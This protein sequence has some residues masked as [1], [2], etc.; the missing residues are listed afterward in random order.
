MRV[1]QG[2]NSL[3]VRRRA[4]NASDAS[5]APRHGIHRQPTHSSACCHV[6]DEKC[7]T[8]RDGPDEPRHDFLQRHVM[9]GRHGQHDVKCPGHHPRHNVRDAIV[10]SRIAARAVARECDH[11]RRSVDAERRNAVRGEGTGQ[12]SI[13][14]AD[15]ERGPRMHWRTEP[16]RLSP[17]MLPLAPLCAV[18]QEASPGVI[19]Q[20]EAQ[21]EA[22][23]LPDE[24]AM[25]WAS[26]Y[27]LMGL[28][29]RPEA[30]AEL[31]RGVRDMKES[32]TYQ[33]ILEE[34][35]SEGSVTEARR[36]IH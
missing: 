22:E 25:L 28:G 15:V 20:L 30:T 2:G 36:L 10:N 26:T 35:R 5:H 14:A 33:A 32:S 18:A 17:G 4:R 9:C 29:F 27:I 23:A 8:R 3:T 12:Q 19:R 31:L 7:P 6:L 11:T 13:A 34:G 21:I 16:R 24:R 1:V